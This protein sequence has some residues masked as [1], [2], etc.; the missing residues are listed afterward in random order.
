METGVQRHEAYTALAAKVSQQV[1]RLL[2]KNWKSFREAKTA[3]EQD[4]S[5]FT[6]HPRLPKY[7]HKTEG[8]NILIYTMQAVSRDEKYLAQGIIKPSQLPITV[9]TKQNPTTLNPVPIAPKKTNYLIN[10]AY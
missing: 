10:V 7:K 6:G 8:R 4:P 3:Y 1:L 9:Q 2:A 5:K